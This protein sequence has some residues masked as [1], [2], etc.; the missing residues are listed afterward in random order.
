MGITSNNVF[1]NRTPISGNQLR[2]PERDFTIQA[3]DFSQIEQ[4]NP[5]PWGRGTFKTAGYQITPIFGFRSEEIKQKIGK[6]K[7]T[8]GYKYNGSYGQAICCGPI[9]Q[10]NTIYNGETPI[11]TG[12][13][14]SS[15][16]D[17]DGKTTLT[18]DLGSTRFYWGS[19]TQNVDSLL[20]SMLID[21]GSG[22]VSVPVPPHRYVGYTVQ[23]DVSFGEQPSP[24]NLVYEIECRT[25]GLTLSA[26]T[27][28]GDA[29]GPEAMY[30]ALT[31]NFFGL[32]LSASDI[33]TAS[34]VDA[35]EVAITEG[36]GVSFLI[37]ELQDA[38]KFF[39]RMNWYMDSFMHLD[40]ESKVAIT[41]T[42]KTS[43]AG[44][45]VIDED[46]LLEEPLPENEG[47]GETWNV[48]NLSFT[49]RENDYEEAIEPFNNAHNLAVRQRIV[50]KEV[51]APWITKRAVAKIVAK[52]EGIKAGIP[53]MPYKLKLLPSHKT[54]RVGDRFKLS[55]SKLGISEVVVR[56]HKITL[57]TRKNP[58]VEV[59]VLEDYTRDPQYDYAIPADVFTQ[60]A[61]VDADGNSAYELAST[62]PRLSALPSGLKNGLLDGFLCAA[63]R[64]T[65]L[66][67]R[68]SIYFTHNPAARN[69]IFLEEALSY[70]AKG[71]IVH[72]FETGESGTWR[73][74]IKFPNTWD[75]NLVQ[76][77]Y[78]YGD[79][80][81]LVVGARH[82][83]T[84]SSAENEH[85]I[86][87]LWLEK[88]QDGI[89]EQF[90]S[91]TWDME[92]EGGSYGTDDL[93]L[94]TGST[95][96]I[97]PTC[98]CY[99]GRVDDFLL[100]GPRNNWLKFER[101][102]GNSTYNSRWNQNSDANLTRYFKAITG[103]SRGYELVADVTES[104]YDRN[105]TTM[106]PDGTYSIEWGERALTG[107]ESFDRA[108]YGEVHGITEA[109]Y[110]DVVDI[111]SGLFLVYQDLD[112]YENW[113]LTHEIDVVL[114]AMIQLGYDHYNKVE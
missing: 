31:N 7:T 44:L 54:M 25:S 101:N 32:G 87:A 86:T 47:M 62:T 90:S 93:L 63:E 8:V 14:D 22:P 74:R 77:L 28:D 110:A 103:N 89:I 30:E 112:S 46:D 13:T 79:P 61:E 40:S 21:Y 15:S 106:N 66:T 37:D 67:D 36:L 95:S 34:F 29:I 60:P 64:P 109:K 39:G 100:Y 12:P 2:R 111:D 97:H 18:H 105:D 55:Y 108:A 91:D 42:R 96:G 104:T 68:L 4:G 48:T 50:K 10:L 35:S 45:I 19:A 33:N 76:L 71:E 38:R 24:P 16:A 92:F 41:M 82:Y 53:Q 6:K 78:D 113:L 72:W 94:A 99:V 107:Y 43:T 73:V 75:F 56:I 11:Y 5:L 81:F 17:G 57:P 69:Y 23:N 98:H 84:G 20:N 83:K 114:G 85:Q 51:N 70:P 27:I 1:A 3:K 58:Q 59:E 65:S 80:L 102:S 9:Y 26:H 88:V 52:R 49:D